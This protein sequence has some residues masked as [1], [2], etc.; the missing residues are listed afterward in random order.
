V[1]LGREKRVSDNSQQAI[2]DKTLNRRGHFYHGWIQSS[3]AADQQV[4]DGE[5]TSRAE[6]SMSFHASCARFLLR[7]CIRL[8]DGSLP[9]V[10]RFNCFRFRRDQEQRRALRHRHR[11]RYYRG[12]ETF[13]DSVNLLAV[14]SSRDT[15]KK[16]KSFCA[17]PNSPRFSRI[18][19]E[20]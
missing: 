13:S 11:R 16:V 10:G 1:G 18:R 2:K 9:A 17:S 5:V 7:I 12:R 15:R 14:A 6:L 8:T 20:N 4:S 3:A 19:N